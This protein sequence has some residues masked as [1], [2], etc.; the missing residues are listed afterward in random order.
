MNA[1]P[2]TNYVLV[3]TALF[4]A[5]DNLFAYVLQ[6]SNPQEKKTLLE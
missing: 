3:L 5:F 4:W 1:P 6:K 2:K